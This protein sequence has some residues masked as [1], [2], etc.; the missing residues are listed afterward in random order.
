MLAIVLLLLGFLPPL[1]TGPLAGVAFITILKREKL[2]YQVPFWFLLVI[3]NLLVMLWVASPAGFWLPIASLPAFFLTPL[4]SILTV[5]VMRNSWRRFEASTQIE[6]SRNRWFML[7][8]VLIPAL[9][10]AAFAAL[11]IYAPSLCK[12]G[13]LV[14]PDLKGL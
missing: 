14:C 10:M 5:F 13:F 6:K 8:L 12:A 9:Q 7:G 2:W 11:L 4:A 1:L 3:L